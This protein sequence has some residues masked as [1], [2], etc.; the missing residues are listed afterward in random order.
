MPDLYV[1]P[2][3]H[4]TATKAEAAKATRREGSKPG[5]WKAVS[6]PTKKGPL[7]DFLNHGWKAPEPEPAKATPSRGPK[8]GARWRVWGGRHPLFIMSTR[9]DN[10]AEAIAETISTLIAKPDPTT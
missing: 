1:T 8:A 7:L 9:A 5:S 6:V 3:G 4:W 2:N 10:A